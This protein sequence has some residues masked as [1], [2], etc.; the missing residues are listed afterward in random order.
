MPRGTILVADRNPKFIEKTNEIL[1]GAGF[2]LV[3]SLDGNEALEQCR[4]ARVDGALLHV[5]LNG[6]SGFQLC[7]AIKDHDPSIP[8]VL[9]FSL[10]D[11]VGAEEAKRAGA[12]NYLIRPL[13]RSEVLFVARSLV[14]QRSAL[15]RVARLNEERAAA[16]KGT[17][18]GIG[19]RLLQF[20]LFKRLLHIELKRSR[21]YGFPLSLLVATLD[22]PAQP[23]DRDGLAAAVRSAIRDIDIPV[24]FGATDVLVVMPHTDLEGGKLV[25]ERV[26][27]K[28]RSGSGKSGHTASVGVVAADGSD[29]MTFSMLLAQA[30]RARKQAARDGG[31]RVVAE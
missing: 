8:V 24:A 1:S 9:M 11:N 23:D 13:K 26:R 19:P 17:M 22:G 4:T 10:E 31:D 20:E 14:A 29:R 16:E 6:L 15:L 18:T 30:T 27:K 28:V 25:G 21:R 3:T 2:R 7:R 12:D 5:V